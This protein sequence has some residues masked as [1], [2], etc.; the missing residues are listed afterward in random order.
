MKNGRLKEAMADFSKCIELEPRFAIHRYNRG[1]F[2]LMAGD[3]TNAE[4]DLRAAVE[5]GDFEAHKLL[6]ELKSIKR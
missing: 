2:L 6:E 5:L 1:T 3:T 4:N